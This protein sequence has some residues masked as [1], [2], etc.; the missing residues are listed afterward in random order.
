MAKAKTAAK[1]TPRAAKSAKTN[2]TAAKGFRAEQVQ[3]IVEKLKTS[4][5]DVLLAG[6]GAFARARAGEGK[7][8]VEDYASLVAEGRKIEPKIKSSMKKAW[9]EIKDKSANIKAPKFDSSKLQGV[10]EERVSAAVSRLGLPAHDE[11]A[12]LNKKLDRLLAA[13]EGKKPAAA[14]KRV[15]KPAAKPAA[16]K[17]AA[18]RAPKAVKPAPKAAPK[19][20]AKPRVKPAAAPAEAAATAQAE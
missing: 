5:H 17:P 3:E 6:L 7:K 11:I 13:A 1:K 4:S 20:V 12:E 14:R 18:K 19:R 2:K 8:S 10:F 15:A 9:G 16:K